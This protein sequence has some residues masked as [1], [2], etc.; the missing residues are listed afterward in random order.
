MP[1]VWVTVATKERIEA[2]MIQGLLTAAGLP[3]RLQGE[4]L[5]SIY[6]LNT[7]P[8]G[9]VAVQVP[10]EVAGQA[11]AILAARFQGADGHER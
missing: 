3:V 11:R 10:A 5:G 6:G 1:D 2:L 9:T 4:A 8:L 7:G